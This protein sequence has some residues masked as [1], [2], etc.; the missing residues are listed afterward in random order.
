VRALASLLVPAWTDGYVQRSFMA[1]IM[2]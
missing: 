2:D 1:E